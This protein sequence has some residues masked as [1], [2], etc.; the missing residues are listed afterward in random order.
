MQKK[1]NKKNRLVYFHFVSSNLQSFS[2]CFI[3]RNVCILIYPLRHPGEISGEVSD[4]WTASYTSSTNTNVAERAEQ[5]TGGSTE[6]KARRHVT[7]THPLIYSFKFT[8]P[9]VD[10]EKRV[11]LRDDGENFHVGDFI[12]H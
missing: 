10:A 12:R 3:F 4:E 6:A 9:R 2:R 1:P 11:F 8:A 7:I 5:P